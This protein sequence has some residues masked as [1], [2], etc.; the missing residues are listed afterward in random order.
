M[1]KKILLIV[2]FMIIIVG[3]VFWL[4]GLKPRDS[5]I[6]DGDS[7]YNVSIDPNN[8]VS[9]VTNRYFTLRKGTKFVY[10]NRTDEGLETIE[11]LVT[12]E[13]KTVMG[14]AMTVVWDRVWLEDVLVEDTRDWYAQ[15]KEGNV[16]YFGEEVDNYVAGV[17]KDNS[18]SWEAGVGGALPGIIMKADPKVGDS[19]RQEYFKGQAEDMA[20]VVALDKGV[21]VPYGSYANCLQSRDWSR[22]ETTL[23]EYKYYC[24]EVGFVVLEEAVSG[25]GERVQLV[26]AATV[27]E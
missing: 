23:N 11:V 24:A 7:I 15:D 3:V 17:L 14:V 10:E 6:N 5:D 21:T 12:T 27:S 16:W 22:I 20:D 4:N 26:S 25:G 9:E 1:Q 8:F 19:Y 2:V 13:A 18:G